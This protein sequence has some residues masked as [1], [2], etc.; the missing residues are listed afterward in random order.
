[1]NKVYR[2]ISNQKS[3]EIEFYEW[4]RRREIEKDKKKKRKENAKTIENKKKKD[5]NKSIEKQKKKSANEIIAVIIL[6]DWTRSTREKSLNDR[7]E[8][9]KWKSTSEIHY[10]RTW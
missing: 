3:K 6:K 10:L 8:I 2:Q 9:K 7:H 5:S 1:M 4:W